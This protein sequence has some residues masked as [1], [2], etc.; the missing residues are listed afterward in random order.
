MHVIRPVTSRDL[1]P[2]L[3]LAH[4]TTFG[5]TTLPRDRNLLDR[6]IR[7]SVRGFEQVE[8]AEP[9][10]QSYLFVLEDTD[11]GGVVGTCGVVSKV[12]G[13]EPFYVYRI[14]TTV[15]ESKM[16]EVRKEIQALH[17]VTEHDGPC[18]IGSLFLH[19]DFRRGGN[20]RLLSLC[21]FLFMADHPDHFA[22]AVVAEMRGVIDEHGHSDFWDALGRHFFDIEF[23]KADYLSIVNKEFIG[24]LMPRHPIYIPLLPPAA[25]E[26]IAQVH[27]ATVP[28]RRLL[29]SEGFEFAGMVDIFEAGPLLRCPRDRIRT[30][31][32]SRCAEV[33]A[34]EERL[35]G[36]ADRLIANRTWD[37]RACR[38]TV[39]VDGE[40]VRLERRVA[41]ALGVHLGDS[42]RFV[43]PRADG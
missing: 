35:T 11:T 8:D 18:E 19:P 10:G 27:P 29:E 4:L 42:V 13:F 23:P 16:L 6:R 17:L 32:A 2:L 15:H 34:V 7:D 22:P 21:R 37:F 30:V 9:R 36:G 5:L 24:D 31:A 38:G 14:E 40:A 3:A 28:A 1:E 20:G 41:D 33:A 39:V 25:R 43:A 12:G 26:V